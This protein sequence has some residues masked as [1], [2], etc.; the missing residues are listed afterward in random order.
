MSAT[1]TTTTTTSAQIIHHTAVFLSETLS[2]PDLRQHLSSTF[3]KRLP[4]TLIIKPLNFAFQ[5]IENA[6][7]TPSPSIQSSSLRLAEKLL[8][9]NSSN[10]FSSYL[11]S[12]VYYLSHREIDASLSLLDVFQADPSFSRLEMAPLLFQELFLIH[13]PPILEWYNEQRS[14]ILSSLSLSSGY[15]SDDQSIV[16]TTRV[17]SKM[18]GHQA[19]ALKDLERDYEVLLDENCRIFVEYFKEVLQNKAGDEM[20]VPP[21]I[22]LHKSERADELSFNSDEEN[23][24][25][26]EFGSTNRRYNVM[27]NFLEFIFFFSLYWYFTYIPVETLI[28]CIILLER[29]KKKNCDNF[30]LQQI[31]ALNCLTGYLAKIL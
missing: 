10:P 15:N 7:S 14:N 1:T 17:L 25:N 16:S 11:L 2:Q 21:T 22:V 19:S 26:Q 20:I 18:S 13:F 24:K 23:I 30:L 29:L 27:L 3:I 9:S 28:E 12:L 31:Y 4:T 6:I 8:L 5:T